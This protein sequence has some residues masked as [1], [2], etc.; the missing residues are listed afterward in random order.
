M[1]KKIDLELHSA[2]AEGLGKY[3]VKIGQY[4]YLK[5]YDF[6]RDTKKIDRIEKKPKSNNITIMTEI[7]ENKWIKYL[8]TLTSNG[9]N[10]KLNHLQNTT[11]KKNGHIWIASKI[12]YLCHNSS[13]NSITDRCFGN[14]LTGL[15]NFWSPHI[16]VYHSRVGG[17]LR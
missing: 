12:K 2:R 6:N 16:P 4:F 5:D 10:I 3:T 1:N 17:L 13:V 9:F 11:L 15:D 8:E 7:D 14:L